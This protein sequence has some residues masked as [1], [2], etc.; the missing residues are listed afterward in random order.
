[1]L[2]GDKMETAE[3]IAYSCNL[4]QQNFKKLYLK[5]TDNGLTQYKKFINLLS[6]KNDGDY[7]SLIVHGQALIDIQKNADLVKK[8]V[9]NVFVKCDSVVCCRMSPKQKGD[10]V[11]LIKKHQNKI[12]LAVGDGANDSNMI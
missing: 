6:N 7:F 10:I 3:N 2:T 9:N 11:R 8:Y 5:K 4:I 1:M 12:T